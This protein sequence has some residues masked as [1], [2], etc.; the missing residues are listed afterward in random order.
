[1]YRKN[2]YMCSYNADTYIFN[3]TTVLISS[4]KTKTKNIRQRTFFQ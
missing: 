1:M 3:C 2:V 4:M